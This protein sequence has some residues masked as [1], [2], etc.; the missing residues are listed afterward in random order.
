MTRNIL[1]QSHQRNEQGAVGVL[2]AV[3]FGTFVVTGLLAWSV[4][5]GQIIL[6]RRQTQSA[7]D[8][9]ALALAQSCAKSNCNLNADG[10]PALVNANTI[11]SATR[12]HP[13]ERQ[14]KSNASIAGTLPVCS[15]SPSVGAL[16]ECPPVP[17]ILAALPYVEVRVR[18]NEGGQPLI[19]NPF[20]QT[21][22][23]GPDTSNVISCARAAWGKPSAAAFTSPITISTCEWDKFSS[24]GTSY[25]P[26]P[27][28]AWPGYGGAGQSPFPL[29][30]TTPNTPGRELMITL[31]DPGDGECPATPSG[32]DAPGGFGYLNTTGTCS[33]T[34]TSTNGV[35]YWAGIDTGANLPNDC[36]VPMANIHDNG[37]TIDLPVFDCIVNDGSGAVTPAMDCNSGNGANAK[38]HLAGVARFFLSGYSLPGGTKNS[39]VTGNPPCGGSV[40]CISGWFVS[41]V[42]SNPTGGVVP[43]G[44]LNYGLSVIVP[45]G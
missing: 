20:T 6:E 19:P 4:D 40:K 29:A 34:A 45:A 3:L 32:G 18:A 27:T 38:Y 12:T 15:S 5:A 35:D 43:P 8:A 16:R 7:A 41:G 21:N 25:Y 9:G 2:V 17:S 23:S 22:N 36:K 30:A 42:L 37:P 10:L 24:G 33:T 39:W 26:P 11:N 28:G 31:H 13:I 14:C 1:L 44:G